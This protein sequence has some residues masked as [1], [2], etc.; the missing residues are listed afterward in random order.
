MAWGV[1]A[2]SSMRGA[3]HAAL[4]A[5]MRKASAS[6]FG[7]SSTTRRT[8]SARPGRRVRPSLVVRARAN[9][10]SSSSA[11]GWS[12]RRSTS[13]SAR[14]ATTWRRSWTSCSSASGTPFVGIAFCSRELPAPARACLGRHFIH[15]PLL[16]RAK[17]TIIIDL[18]SATGVLHDGAFQHVHREALDR[19]LADVG[20]LCVCDARVGATPLHPPKSR[21]AA[22]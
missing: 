7:I 15:R 18:P 1:T 19:W 10:S 3:L 5:Q 11:D 9:R 2:L 21:A 22:C 8:P 17:H 12:A 16:Q 13:S 20:N 4:A 14:A 6:A